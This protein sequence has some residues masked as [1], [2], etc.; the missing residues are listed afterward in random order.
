MQIP[1]FF[2]KKGLPSFPEVWYAKNGDTVSN[3]MY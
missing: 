2:K 1:A 3:V